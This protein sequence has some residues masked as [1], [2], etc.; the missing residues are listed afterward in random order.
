MKVSCGVALVT[1]EPRPR[2]LLLRRAANVGNPCTWGLPGGQRDEA[3]APRNL[4]WTAQRECMEEMGF[5]P[6]THA[7]LISIRRGA[8][9]VYHVFCVKVSGPEN[10]HVMLNKE[11][12][13]HA[14]VAIGAPQPLQPLHPVVTTLLTTHVA[15]LVT[16]MARTR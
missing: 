12:T 4:F 3:D 13:E 15:S 14:W 11:H 16:P 10:M 9:K 2:I 8:A 6:R 1:D 5:A 7:A